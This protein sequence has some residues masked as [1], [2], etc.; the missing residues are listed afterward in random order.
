MFI[1]SSNRLLE[2]EIQKFNRLY[3]F[4]NIPNLDSEKIII[5]DS[6]AF[7]MSMSKKRMDAEYI[8]KLAQHY[9][10]Y[11]TQENVHCIA[12]DVFKDPKKSIRQFIAFRENYS[13]IKASPVLQFYSS[14]IDL[15]S[16]KKQIE[17]YSKLSNSRMVCI[18]NNK[19][20]AQKQ[21]REIRFIVDEIRDKFGDVLIHVLGAG[22]SHN[23]VK[24]WL[25]AGV[26]SLDSI[27][28]YT[29]AQHKLS[30]V[31][32]SYETRFSNLSFRELA[33]HNAS[34]ANS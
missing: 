27:S 24:D 12:P 13:D 8:N 31:M 7:A 23:N 18:S 9:R 22:Y 2:P 34:I 14:Q 5:L 21:L 30:W 1:L 15:F 3:A 6:G 25:K 32:N 17:T 11:A 28:Y 4:P 16:T 33:L 29:D 19:F 20:N 10:K 26:T